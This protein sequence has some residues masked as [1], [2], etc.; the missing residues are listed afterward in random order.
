MIGQGREMRGQSKLT[1]G[2]DSQMRGRGRLMIGQGREMR[3]QSKLTRGR[4]RQTRGTDR[5][6]GQKGRKGNASQRN[7]GR[8]NTRNTRSLTRRGDTRGRFLRRT[9]HTLSD[10]MTMTMMLRMRAECDKS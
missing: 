10:D 6:R 5:Q 3:G 7:E 8:R 1:R 9:K 2:L 4:G